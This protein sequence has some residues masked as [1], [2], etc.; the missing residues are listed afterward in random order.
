MSRA[1]VAGAALLA[2]F[3]VAPSL[4]AQPESAAPAQQ[5]PTR[6]RVVLLAIDSEVPLVARIA[7]ELRSLRFEVVTA[8][9]E[10]LAPSGPELEA[11]ARAYEARAAVQVATGASSIELWLVNLE[12][13]ELVYRRILADRDPAVAAF[14]SL[15]ILR[16]SLIDLQAL[17]PAITQP[18]PAK[19]QRKLER[20][21]NSRPTPASAQPRWLSL[22]LG[23][24]V[25][26]AGN[27]ITPAWYAAAS[28]RSLLGKHWVLNG[29]GLAP[30]SSASIVGDAGS[31]RLRTGLLGA[32]LSFQPWQDSLLTPA[33]GAGVAGVVLHTRGMPAAGYSGNTQLDFAVYPHARLEV[34]A[35][36]SRLFRVRADLLGGA[37]MPRPVVVFADQR[38]GAWGSSLFIVGLEMELVFR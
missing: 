21:T 6:T 16:G 27:E 8:K 31:A 29:F 36:L 25:A 19:P 11:V 15:E 12:T 28:A 4:H 38:V 20:P 37:V 32:G 3:G 23:A 14:R 24:A 13:H 33:V 35:A 7:A 9:A 34:S 26:N 18:E 2:S 22:S 1:A 17:A 5:N 30:V 10:S